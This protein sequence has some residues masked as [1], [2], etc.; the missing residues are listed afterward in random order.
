MVAPGL[1][2]LTHVPRPLAHT[3]IV[4]CVHLCSVMH[5]CKDENFSIFSCVYWLITL[6]TVGFFTTLFFHNPV[7]RSGVKIYTSSKIEVN[8]LMC[9]KHWNAM[10]TWK[11]STWADCSLSFDK[12]QHFSLDSPGCFSHC[13]SVWKEVSSWLRT[14]DFKAV[15]HLKLNWPR[16][17]GVTN[18]CIK[19]HIPYQPLPAHMMLLNLFTNN[20][21]SECWFC[22]GRD[23]Y[24]WEMVL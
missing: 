16:W 20:I 5:A 19:T 23:L 3:R 10:I 24:H 14:F 6:H 9:M 15:S 18:L 21:D 12:L 1:E 11:C 22:V 17:I 2:H 7:S 8:S 13:K 4:A